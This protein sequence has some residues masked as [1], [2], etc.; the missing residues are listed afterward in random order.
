MNDSR[1]TRLTGQRKKPAR[2]V[3]LVNGG[4][5]VT[6]TI[7]TVRPRAGDTLDTYC[8]EQF[9]ANG[10]RGFLLFKPDRTSYATCLA[11]NDGV[12]DCKGFASHSHCKHVEALLALERAGKLQPPP[13][14]R[15][16]PPRPPHTRKGADHAL[17]TRN[18][19]PK[20]AVDHAA[21]SALLEVTRTPARCLASQRQRHGVGGGAY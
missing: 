13:F 8:L 1:G 5:E 17:S 7:R 4:D 10:G 20:P 12:C 2:F 11:G 6:I 19:A 21:R 9:A 15:G 16:R 3:K 18:T 14:G